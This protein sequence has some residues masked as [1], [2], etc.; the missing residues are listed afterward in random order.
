MNSRIE[1]VLAKIPAWKNGAVVTPLTGG[2]T[3]EN[4]RID[5]NG[6]SFV[7]RLCGKNTDMLGIDRRHEQACAAIVAKIG[8]GP[9]VFPFSQ[10]HDVLCTKFINGKPV[11]PEEIVQPAMLHRIV[12]TIRQ[13]HEG[14]DFPGLFSAFETVKSYHQLA[15]RHAVSF[16]TT[17]SYVFTLMMRMERALAK[18]SRLCPCHNDLLASNF[19]DDGRKIWILDWEYAAMGDLFFDL[20]NFA[21]NQGLNE[22]QMEMLLKSYFGHVRKADVAH[23]HLMRLVSDLRE[24]FWGFLQ[25]GIS[26][27]DFDYYSYA[28]KHLERFLNNASTSLFEQWLRDVNEIKQAS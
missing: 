2:I 25:V 9:E 23:I 8:I 5:V 28:Q 12:Q 11:I 26:T 16:P 7:L 27:L 21:V 20:G 22:Q 15:C 4:Y 18:V 10:F 1:N 24:A 13:Y 3:N 17:L 14:P 6:E 19:L